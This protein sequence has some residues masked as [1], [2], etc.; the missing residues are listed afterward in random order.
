MSYRSQRSKRF[1]RINAGKASAL[2]QSQP[3]TEEQWAVLRREGKRTGRQFPPDITRGAA[4]A[5]IKGRFDALPDAKRRSR[6]AQ[7]RRA[8]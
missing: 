6:R 5:I 3:A 8:T 4:S 7:R 2:W 1:Q